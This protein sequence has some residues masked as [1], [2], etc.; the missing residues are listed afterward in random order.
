MEGTIIFDTGSQQSYISQTAVAQ[1]GLRRR[2]SKVLT[3][4]TFGK[5]EG[6]TQECDVVTVGLKRSDASFHELSLLSFPSICGTIKG[7]SELDLKDRYPVVPS[8]PG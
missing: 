5:E 1:L 3:N 2:G 6:R 8:R 7:M 4:A